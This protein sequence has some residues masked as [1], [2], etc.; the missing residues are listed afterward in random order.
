MQSLEYPDKTS[1]FFFSARNLL[2][3]KK[4]VLYRKGVICSQGFDEDDELFL[5]FF[6]RRNHN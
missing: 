5:L 3:K 4:K 1:I 2:G 6:V